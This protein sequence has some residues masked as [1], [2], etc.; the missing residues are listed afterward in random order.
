MKEEDDDA[1]AKAFVYSTTVWTP[2]NICCALLYVEN[3]GLTQPSYFYYLN[4]SGTYKV[5]GTDDSKEFEATMVG[6]ND[7]LNIVLLLTI[8]YYYY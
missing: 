4:Q 1:F 8:Y 2:F 5:D 7:V 3:L 6:N